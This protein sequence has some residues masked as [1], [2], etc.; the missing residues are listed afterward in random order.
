MYT[1][2]NFTPVEA[3][4]GGALIGFSAVLMLAFNGR[5]AGIS[6]IVGNILHPFAH[7]R[8]W[9]MAFIV[10]LLGGAALYGVLAPAGLVVQIDVGWPM[11]LLA[12]L[13]VGAGTR[14]SR[15][16][17]SGHGVCGIGRLSVRSMAAT[18]VF[19]SVAAL[20]VFVVRHLLGV[21]A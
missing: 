8:S 20:T 1:I 14:L 18:A 6:G 15:G 16:C 3:L 19:M 12:G 9:R 2:T 21:G 7:E 11:L 4:V 13:I 17:T 10:G 5:I